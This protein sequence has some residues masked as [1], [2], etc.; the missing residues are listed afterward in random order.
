MPEGL[1]HCAV[2]DEVDARVDHEE[3]VVEGD[4]REKGGREVGAAQRQA[5][6]VV[7]LRALLRVQ[8]L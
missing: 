7:V 8:R 3:E 5:V 1:P 2:D 4:Q 6:V